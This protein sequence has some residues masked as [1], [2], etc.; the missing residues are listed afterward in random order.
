MAANEKRFITVTAGDRI[1]TLA[2]KAYGDVYKYPLLLAANPDLD[3]WYPEPGLKIEV[4][5]A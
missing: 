5:D 3:I 4:P 2:L 1:D